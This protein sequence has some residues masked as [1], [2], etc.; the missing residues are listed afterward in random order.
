[1]VGTSASVTVTVKEQL[2]ELRPA[3]SVAT[4]V[5]VLTPLLKAAPE[6]TGPT[7]APAEVQAKVTPGQLSAGVTVNVVAAVHNPGSVFL[8]MGEGQAMVGTSLSVTVTGKE[9]LAELS[10][11]PSL[12]IHVT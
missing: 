4:Q 7:V 3:A 10:P 12:A 2:A 9:Q 5:T 1:M 8:A 11:A 6:T